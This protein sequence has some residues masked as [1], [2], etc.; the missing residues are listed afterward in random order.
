M[1]ALPATAAGGRDKKIHING[2]D[3]DW[4]DVPVFLV[5]GSG[6]GTITDGGAVYHAGGDI[7]SLRIQNTTC[8]VFFLLE[9]PQRPDVPA[10]LV[11]DLDRDESTGCTPF[12]GAEALVQVGRS[13][14]EEIQRL[15][16]FSGCGIPRLLDFSLEMKS[17]AGRDGIEISL[18][19]GVLQLIAPGTQGFSIHASTG[20]ATDP[21]PDFLLPPL[22][23]E[24]DPPFSESCP[25]PEVPPPGG[26]IAPG[27]LLPPPPPPP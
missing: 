15:G 24:P 5:D 7:L 12:L 27:T 10:N 21:S 26:S 6:D 9:L 19:V 4:T 1:F 23:Y 20:L 25:A 14:G 8:E 18:P 3:S 11:L 22:E 16:E 2:N 13:E 17:R